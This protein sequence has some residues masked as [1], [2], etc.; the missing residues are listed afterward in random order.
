PPGIRSAGF[1]VYARL[2]TLAPCRYLPRLTLSAVLP[3]PNTSNAAPMRGVMS[4][5]PVTP[6]V[7]AKLAPGKNRDWGSVCAGNQL[8]GWSQR[9]APWKVKRL[10]VH[11]S[12]A[13]KDNCIASAFTLYALAYSVIDRGRV[14]RN[15]YRRF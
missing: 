6:S 5:Y 13:Y 8:H 11:W 14:P 3:V 7:R 1:A 4:L 9:S 12:C 2:L 15:V 10:I